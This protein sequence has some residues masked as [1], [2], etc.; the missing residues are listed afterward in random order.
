MKKKIA[1][2]L[3]L[4]AMI[5][6]GVIV[7][8]Q[9]TFKR[10]AAKLQVESETIAA[11]YLALASENMLPLTQAYELT[12][13]QEKIAE[14]VKEDKA[15][16]EQADTLEERLQNISKLQVALVSFIKSVTADQP[17]VKDSDF[18]ELQK[19]M[20]ERGEMRTHLTAFNTTA[21]RWN[22]GLQSE[23]GSLAARI[24]NT[25]RNVLPYLRFDGEQEYVTIVEL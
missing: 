5:T 15:K 14:R 7:Y 9:M 4:A 6:G 2:F 18:I 23:V 11:G 10:L 19:E 1:S 12:P 3:V 8:E 24:G 16:L 17:L 22:N 20:G 25:S 13:T 21:L